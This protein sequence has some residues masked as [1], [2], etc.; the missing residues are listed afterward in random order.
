MSWLPSL[1]RLAGLV[2]MVLLLLFV[3]DLHQLGRTLVSIEPG[4]AVAALL[5]NLPILALKTERWR[6][7]L[8]ALQISYPFRRAFVAFT[9]GLPASIVTPGHVGE[10]A[11]VMYLKADL[12]LS[13]GIGLFSV[14]VD[15]LLDL[16]L[17]SFVGGTALA[18][19]QLHWSLP[20]WVF[21]VLG[22]V[23]IA[24]LLLAIPAVRKRVAGFFERKRAKD[25]DRRSDG[26]GRLSDA[27]VKGTARV[28]GGSSERALFHAV[29][30]T[31]LA[32]CL[33]AAQTFFLACGLGLPLSFWEILLI[34]GLA[35]LVSALPLS[36]AGVGTREA[37]LVLLF[38]GRGIAA[39]YALA[40]GAAILVCNVAFCFAM[41]FAVWE[42][43]PPTRR[44]I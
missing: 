5:A 13:A 21:P 8:M 32:F 42:I 25:G 14:V 30:F 11:R 28:L 31:L 19:W 36:V 33:L 10:L 18:V 29:V 22:P 40:L 3:V 27:W 38:A 15:R 16:M 43:W 24:P 39:E 44:R 34:I 26:L 23:V 1:L 17:L 41:G 37:V 35:N 4:W 6:R 20:V 7:V 9:G 2:A 12:D